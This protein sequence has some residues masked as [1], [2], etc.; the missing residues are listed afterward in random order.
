MTESE[1]KIKA[2]MDIVRQH[3]GENI[4]VRRQIDPQREEPGY[5][6]KQKEKE[7]GDISSW[8]GASM[9]GGVW[10]GRQR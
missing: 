7:R 3:T 1:R 4:E 5:F 2:G 6:V 10:A 8:S 9:G